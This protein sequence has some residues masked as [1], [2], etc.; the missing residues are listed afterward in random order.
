M[1]A[2]ELDASKQVLESCN[3]VKLLPTCRKKNTSNVHAL[4]SRDSIND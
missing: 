3:Y 4:E 1:L 2:S